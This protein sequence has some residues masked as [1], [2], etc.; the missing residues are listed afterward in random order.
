M[1]DCFPLS[2]YK[3]IT[4]DTASNSV[5]NDG[6]YRVVSTACYFSATSQANLAGLRTI[7]SA[8]IVQRS[9]HCLSSN[10]F[11]LSLN[12]AEASEHLSCASY[13]VHDV[14]WIVVSMLA[15]QKSTVK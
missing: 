3:L 2:F 4:A 14:E 12:E 13:F 11:S 8:R 5:Q 9:D 10:E 1:P 7:G 6:G 15:S